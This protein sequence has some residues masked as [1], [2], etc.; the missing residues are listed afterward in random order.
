MFFIDFFQVSEPRVKI[1][2]HDRNL[3]ASLVFTYGN[4]I[5]TA[6][7]VYKMIDACTLG[8]NKSRAYST[9]L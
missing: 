7:S 1:K 6:T 9:R 2:M 3:V 8:G 4:M 5:V